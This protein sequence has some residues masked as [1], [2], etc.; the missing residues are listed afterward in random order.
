MSLN[1]ISVQ[2]YAYSAAIRRA[3][4]MLIARL[5][6][7]NCGTAE[8]TIAASEMVGM[9]ASIAASSA[10][11]AKHLRSVAKH[12]VDASH[13]GDKRAYVRG[14]HRQGHHFKT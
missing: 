14:S 8:T 6:N 3:S 5:A 2:T 1:E 12:D 11:R 4:R 9:K 7:A 10:R 13:V